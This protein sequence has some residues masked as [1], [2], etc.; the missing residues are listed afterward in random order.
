ME[1]LGFPRLGVYLV[2]G[3]GR[4]DGVWKGDEMRDRGGWM[5]GWDGMEF[6]GEM[7]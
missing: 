4:G 7:R 6:W 2:L 3:P 1:F 5:G